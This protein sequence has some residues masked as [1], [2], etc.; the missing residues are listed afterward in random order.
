M[1]DVLE[2]I[3]RMELVPAAVYYLERRSFPVDPES[4]KIR[5]GRTIAVYLKERIQGIG[6]HLLQK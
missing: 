6:V 2:R 4:E 5:D 3:G 1:G